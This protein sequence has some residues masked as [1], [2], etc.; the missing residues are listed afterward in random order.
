MLLDSKPM[1]KL[2]LL[3]SPIYLRNPH[4][5]WNMKRMK[6]YM[7]KKYS[8]NLKGIAFF[9]FREYGKFVITFFWFSLSFFVVLNCIVFDFFYITIFFFSFN[10]HPKP[11]K[12]PH[13]L[14]RDS[15]EKEWECNNW[16]KKSLTFMFVL[17]LMFFFM[18]VISERIRVLRT[19]TRKLMS[20]NIFSI[21][22]KD[23]YDINLF[24]PLQY[25]INLYIF[26]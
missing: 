3:R 6:I 16:S 4:A 24:S 5:K 7:Q 18:K 19:T 13:I 14:Y 15:V 22:H 20:S 10:M 17:C 9:F 8:F 25:T 26:L 11:K 23:K 1:F 2:Q 12:K 21:I